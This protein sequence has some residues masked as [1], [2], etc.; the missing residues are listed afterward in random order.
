MERFKYV[1]L[2]Q[3]RNMPHIDFTAEVLKEKRLSSFKPEQLA[4]MALISVTLEVLKLETLSSFKLEQPINIPLISVTAEVL[5]FSIPSIVER[6]C[7]EENQAFVVVGKKF[8]NEASKTT[9]VVSKLGFKLAQA[10]IF[11][12]PSSLAFCCSSISQVLPLRNVLFTS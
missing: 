1:K 4:N 11:S 8:L 6:F 9:F 3:P 7:K 10:G 12:V 5:R 2:E